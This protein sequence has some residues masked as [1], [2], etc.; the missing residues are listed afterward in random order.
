LAH[1]TWTLVGGEGRNH[2]V[3]LYHG[4]RTGHVMIYCG[5]KIMQIDFSVLQ[6]KTYSFFIEDE[7]CEIKLERKGDTFYY[8]FEI[9]KEVDTPLNRHRKKLNRKHWKQTTVFFGVAILITILISVGIQQFKRS[10]SDEAYQEL[11]AGEA[12]DST[13]AIIT[14][15]PEG[16][17]KEARFSYLVQNQQLEGKI[18]VTRPGATFFPLEMGDEFH[19]V[20]HPDYPKVYLL[21]LSGPTE[22][23]LDRYEQRAIDRHLTEH[24]DAYPPHVSCLVNLAF[25]RQGLA[26]LATVF[27][28]QTPPTQH[29]YFNQNAFQRM[30]RDPEF[31][32]AYRQLCWE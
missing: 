27:H 4:Q 20:V 25:E 15:L 31:D 11:I 30:V 13:V 24:P 18:E 23:Q 19:L 7:F 22:K 10:P 29:P 12:G 5:S 21:K 1:C 6:S 9:N 3:G 26:G 16:E 32:Q 17:V 8:T 28:Q 2:Q 14:H